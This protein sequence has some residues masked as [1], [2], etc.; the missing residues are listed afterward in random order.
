MSKFTVLW[1]ALVATAVSPGLVPGVDAKAPRQ[2][3]CQPC[4][5]GNDQ[6]QQYTAGPFHYPTATSVRYATSVGKPTAPPP[7]YAPAPA[8][9]TSL[10]LPLEYTTW[11]KWNP[12]VPNFGQ[13]GVNG[14]YGKNAWSKMWS[15]A[16]LP[17]FPPKTSV[18]ST[19]VVP[20]PVP[21]SELVF[22]PKDHFGPSSDTGCCYTFPP[23]FMFGV[24]GAAAQI[25][26]AIADQGRSP[27]LPD[28]LGIIPS[29]ANDYT[30]DE[31]YYYYKQDIER[32]AA[33]G[34]KYYSFSVSWTRI[35]PFALPGT[36]VN[37]QGIDHY[38]DVINF[39]LEKGMVPV[40]TLMHFDPPVQMFS[41]LINNLDGLSF[42]TGIFSQFAPT[43]GNSSLTGSIPRQG[44]GVDM[45]KLTDLAKLLGF[46]GLVELS[47]LG[48][49]SSSSSIPHNVTFHDAFLNYAK[50]VMTHYA[51]RVPLW[52]T[53]NEPQMFNY[54]SKA[55]DGIL[56][57]HA[58]TYHFYKN[59]LKGTGNITIKFAN[60]YGVPRDPT[61]DADVY[62]ADWFNSFAIGMFADPLF[63][64]K[65]YPVSFKALYPNHTPLTPKD[66]E[67]MNGTVD[68]L[69][70]DYYSSTVV[71]SP[72]AGDK[73]SIL[74]CTKDAS[75]PLRSSQCVKAEFVD[76]NGWSVGYRSQ[77]YVRTTP[78]LLRSYL[79]YLYT[80]WRK[81]IALT[82]FGFPVFA[83][84]EKELTDQLFD[85][86][87]TTYY[88]S[89]LSE[90]LKAI[91]EDGVDVVGAFA[92]SFADNWEW[93]DYKAQFGLQTV[94]RT[95]QQRHYKKSF[96]DL[97]DFM[98]SRGAE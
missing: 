94:N 91:W 78:T 22:P 43:A 57:A 97:V 90:L 52:V 56:R 28:V 75:H 9:A 67:F 79:N 27:A 42:A 32:L 3:Q 69:S 73:D 63:H 33:M 34:V 30:T 83:E 54:D 49:N 29:M 60:N 51:D 47:G 76:K 39:V 84:G 41:S 64:G 16:N 25:E 13:E 58:S 71:S 70:F 46:G 87:R 37:K 4:S 72:V 88:L 89:Y 15:L 85:T 92:W 48:G 65:D 66:L 20:T 18:F 6:E 53:V 93:G 2:S 14:R 12:W 50:V 26:G 7:T 36:P 96:F 80:N 77:S 40:V 10:V 62:A 68:I 17:N 38:N 44:M 86:P 61:S 45:K 35:L 1:L 21:T 5:N 74:A 81:P 82:E 59:E 19:T 11:G 95:T 8:E 55:I 23:N 31:H 24:A 98:K